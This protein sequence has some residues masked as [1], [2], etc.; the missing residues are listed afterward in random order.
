MAKT[1]KEK[2]V[3]VVEEN[4]SA[5]KM[6]SAIVREE[7][8]YK[9]DSLESALKAMAILRKAEQ[10]FL[11]LTSK[12]YKK[13]KETYVDPEVADMHEYNKEYTIEMPHH[14]ANVVYKAA[15]AIKYSRGSKAGD[16]AEL[17]KV[18]PDLVE[19]K[20]TLYLRSKAQ[21]EKL[22]DLDGAL[23]DGYLDKAESL[24]LKESIKNKGVK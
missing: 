19:E 7:E 12:A 16:N 15:Q 1:K 2:V 13:I 21:L 11:V 6:A 5:I 20:T 17:Q 23:R 14:D 24:S 18:Y 22:E 10:D 4:S 9:V 8:G 3:V